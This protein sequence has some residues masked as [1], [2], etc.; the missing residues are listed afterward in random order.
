MAKST[1]PLV[2]CLP[3]PAKWPTGLRSIGLRKGQKMAILLGNRIDTLDCQGGIGRVGLTTIPL[4]PRH[5][6][7]EQEYILNNAEADA[8]IMSAEFIDSISPVLPSVPTLKKVIVMGAKGGEAQE[9]LAYE[10]LVEGQP[11]SA[12][13]AGTGDDH[14]DRIQYTSGTTGRPKGAVSTS[15]LSYNRIIN[16]L[17]NLGSA[18]PA[19]GCQYGRRPPGPRGRPDERGL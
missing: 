13:T 8:L 17:I 15:L 16:V 18:D 1:L 11:E 14:I 10:K 5:S 6:P 19:F 12:P 7:R 9:M 3:G 4:N 2:K